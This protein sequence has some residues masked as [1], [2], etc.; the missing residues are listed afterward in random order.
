MK[1]VMDSST[2]ISVSSNC[3]MN[4]F[5]RYCKKNNIKPI[6]TPAVYSESISRPWH[7]KRFELNAVRIKDAVDSG[8]IAVAVINKQIAFDSQRL[9]DLAN[10]VASLK[11][12]NLKIFHRGEAEAVALAKNISARVLAVDERT[13]RTLIEAPQ[14]MQSFLTRRYRG[15]VVVS[16]EKAREFQE[17]VSDLL[18]LRSTELFALAHADDCFPPDMKTTP[19]ALEAAL[20][21]AK[22][23]GCAISF[24][25]IQEHLKK[26]R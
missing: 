17:E 25:E 2:L 9:M 19:K 6:I 8:L 5:N 4:V 10:S 24:K 1:M 15:D 22:F 14:S 21:A 13:T 16:Q 18:I 3:F 26:Q 7:I 12:R 23:G 11:Q 20:Y